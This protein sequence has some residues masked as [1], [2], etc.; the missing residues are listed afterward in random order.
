[1]TDVVKQANLLIEVRNLHRVLTTDNPFKPI[2]L[3]KFGV[4]AKFLTDICESYIAQAEEIKRLK[5]VIQSIWEVDTDNFEDDVREINKIVA[6]ELE[7]T[8]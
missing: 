8:K 7:E 6:K 2:P 4:Q 5:Q 1:M 3:S